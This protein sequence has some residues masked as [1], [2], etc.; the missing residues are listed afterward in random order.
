MTAI[1][2]SNI[3]P[4]IRFWSILLSSSVMISGE[5]KISIYTLVKMHACEQKTRD[6]LG[7]III[8]SGKM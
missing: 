8:E 5:I 4:V 3:H 7:L 1:K 2:E 6:G